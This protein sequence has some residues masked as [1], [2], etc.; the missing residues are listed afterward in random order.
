VAEIARS[1][2]PHPFA[3][4]PPW[5]PLLRELT[6]RS[7]LWG[8]WK[9]ADAAIAGHG[10]IDA[11][12]SPQ[13]RELLVEAFTRWASQYDMGPVIRC[14]HLPGSHLAVAVRG[15]ELVEL[16]L[17]E[18]ALLRGATL[19]T[20]RQLQP[21]MV[22]D[23][24]GFRR[25][26]SGAEAFLLVFHVVL[27]PGGRF[28]PAGLERKPIL[29]MM[30]D[31]PAGV[32]AAARAVFGPVRKPSLAVAE[33]LLAGRWDRRSALE[34]EA[35]IAARG[36]LHPGLWASWARGHLPGGHGCPL[37]PALRGGRRIEGDVPDWVA[38][39]QRLHAA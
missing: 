23:P 18:R 22:M 29:A 21:M 8:V 1:D 27:R 14:P 7:P 37:L 17:N 28:S 35:W 31:D 2:A 24:R 20:A 11:T 34:V 38:R 4:P 6:E 9:N 36:A 10:D 33:A 16:Q 3:A 12:S 30:R 39:V 19:F 26:R 15:D 32:R 13:D 5:V 25:L